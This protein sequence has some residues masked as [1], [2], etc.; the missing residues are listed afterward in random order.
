MKTYF[1]VEDLSLERL[2][3]EWR[4]LCPQTVSLVAR[5]AFGDLYLRDKSGQISKLD[6]AIGR[7]NSR[8]LAIWP[9]MR[10]LVRA[11]YRRCILLAAK[12]VEEFV[13][14]IEMPQV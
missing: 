5:T 2:L 8:E 10:W 4:W 7:M 1:Q 3:K 11:E 13:S 6:I 14:C 12:G 9:A